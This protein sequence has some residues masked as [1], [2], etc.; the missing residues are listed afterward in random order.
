MTMTAND[1]GG[2][3]AGD[4]TGRPV[5]LLVDDDPVVVRALSLLLDRAGFVVAGCGTAADAVARVAGTPAV[6]AAVLDIHLPDANG[7]TLSQQLRGLVGP[8]VPIIILSGDNSMQTIRALPD[9]GATYFFA[10]PV[11]TA[12]LIAQLREWTARS[13]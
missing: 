5:V 10:K 9:A 1:E 4:G 6:S 7:L 3:M 12:M 13:E 11:N 8:A 2:P